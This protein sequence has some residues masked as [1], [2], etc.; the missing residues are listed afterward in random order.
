MVIAKKGSE[1]L[2]SSSAF[3]VCP[4]KLDWLCRKTSIEDLMDK[5]AV[6]IFCRKSVFPTSLKGS[7]E[8]NRETLNVDAL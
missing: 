3:N 5:L 8:V 1:L 6:G 4:R 2:R 7:L